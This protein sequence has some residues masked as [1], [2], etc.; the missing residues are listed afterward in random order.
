MRYTMFVKWTCHQDS[1]SFSIYNREYIYMNIYEQSVPRHM[2]EMCVWCVHGGK[3]CMQIKCDM[4]KIEKDSEGTLKERRRELFMNCMYD[5]GE[6]SANGSISVW[7]AYV[8]L[9]FNKI[10]NDFFSLKVCIVCCKCSCREKKTEHIDYIVCNQ[11]MFM[12]VVV[13]VVVIPKAIARR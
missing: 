12:H 6:G 4:T 7:H 11:W 2:Y 1:D 5:A 8:V 10:I 13:V 9:F 3:S